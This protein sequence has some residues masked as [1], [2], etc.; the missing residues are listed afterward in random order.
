MHFEKHL[1]RP[2]ENDSYSNENIILNGVRGGELS[3]SMS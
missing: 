2:L 3:L 1:K